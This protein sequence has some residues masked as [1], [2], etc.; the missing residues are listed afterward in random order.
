MIWHGVALVGQAVDHRYGRGLSEALDVLVAVGADHHRVDHARQH[1][2]GV[3]DGLAAAQLHVGRGGDDAIAAQLA[4]GRVEPEAGAGRVLLEDHR[5][6]AVLGR[7]V[8]V[9]AAPWASRR[10]RPCGPWRPR[11]S[12]AGRAAAQLPQVDEVSGFGHRPARSLRPTPGSSGFV[13]SRSGLRRRPWP[14]RPRRPFSSFAT[15]SR[16]FLDRQVQRR[17]QAHAVVAAASDQQAAR[18]GPGP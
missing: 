13:V 11:A 5:Q 16:R 10:G 2:G 18:R 4:D 1:L 14:G 6:R 9:D 17:Q 7:G 3:L 15:A 8:V 12:R